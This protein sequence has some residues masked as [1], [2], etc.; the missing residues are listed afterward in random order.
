MNVIKIYGGLGNQLF[1]YSFGQAMVANGIN[2]GYDI[3]YF[4]R[5]QVY[6]RPYSLDRF[7]IGSIPLG[8]LSKRK[9]INEVRLG[10]VMNLDYLKMD[11]HNF[12]GYWQ[13]PGYFDAIF[14]ELQDQFRVQ[15]EFYTEEFLELR[16]KV[17]CSNSVALHVRRTDYIQI[18]G[19]FLLSKE[20]HDNAIKLMR[21]AIGDCQFYI[22]SD[23]LPWCRKNFDGLGTFVEL[24]E[25]YLAFDL[26]RVCKHQIIANSTFSWWAARLNYTKYKKVICPARWWKN[27]KDLARN[28]PAFLHPEVS[29]TVIDSPG[30]IT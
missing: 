3:S 14:S 20:Y 16:E 2:V 19:H 1:Q 28:D 4:S 30:I 22:F 15:K 7:Y 26:M 10:H 23:D 11:G 18:K 12:Y 17:I 25:D 13:H 6:P 27:D 29:W 24:K 8:K 9:E 5:P 21:E